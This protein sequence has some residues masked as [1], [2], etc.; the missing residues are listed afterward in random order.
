MRPINL[1]HSDYDSANFESWTDVQPGY[2]ITSNV[3]LT[4]NNT[5]IWFYC[6]DEAIEENAESAIAKQARI[7]Q[8]DVEGASVVSIEL[9]T[10]SQMSLVELAKLLASQGVTG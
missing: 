1:E 5:G 6:F 4:T 10:L 9:S 7:I 2:L 8:L 3:V